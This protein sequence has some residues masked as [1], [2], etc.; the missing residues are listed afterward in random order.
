MQLRLTESSKN[1]MIQELAT[2]I[3]KIHGGSAD[4]TKPSYVEV[5]GAGEKSDEE[6]SAI[7]AS[8]GKAIEFINAYGELF[9]SAE[10]LKGVIGMA[11]KLSSDAI[12]VETTIH[13]A[14]IITIIDEYYKERDNAKNG[15]GIIGR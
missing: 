3:I 1:K 2:E 12:G 13:K 6:I 5:C 10:E 11:G 15:G 9:S 7:K 8:Q 14:P 4:A